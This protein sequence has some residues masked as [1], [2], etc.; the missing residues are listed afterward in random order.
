[1]AGAAETIHASCVALG[2]RGVLLLGPSGAGKSDLALRLIM[3]SAPAAA[4]GVLVA[5]DRVVLSVHDGAL[6]A[7]APAPIAGRIEVRGLGIHR[8]PHRPWV[9]L[10]LAV[11]LVAREAVP[12]LP[13]VPSERSWLGI[14]LPAVA[15]FP[16]E[17]SAPLKVR[18]AL[19]RCADT[20][21]G[22][23]S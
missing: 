18:L 23:E 5:D 8:L 9:R 11:D 22:G 4:R 14:S 17:A 19:E 21:P 2:Q 6:R 15:L 7:H 3:E 12:R 1:M 13:E 10:A 20:F 16:F